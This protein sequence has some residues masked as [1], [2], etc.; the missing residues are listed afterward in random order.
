MEVCTIKAKSPEKKKTKKSDAKEAVRRRLL[1]LRENPDFKVVVVAG[2]TG[3]GR[4]FAES[5]QLKTKREAERTRAC[6][7]TPSGSVVLIQLLMPH[8]R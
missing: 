8:A 2:R 3:S 5:Q 1:R 6:D 7:C 4:R